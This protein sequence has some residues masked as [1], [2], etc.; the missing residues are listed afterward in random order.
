MNS[1]KKAIYILALFMI[2][3]TVASASI[4][5]ETNVKPTTI[6][7]GDH[8]ELNVDISRDSS[9]NIIEPPLKNKLGPFKV[10]EYIRED[11]INIDDDKIRDRFSYRLSTYETGE[12][13]IS[14][15]RFA[16]SAGAD[17]SGY[18]S[19]GEIRI[20]VQSVLSPE[21]S[22]KIRTL[23]QTQSQ[24]MPGM[25]PGQGIQASPGKAQP[26]Q[27]QSP[28]PPIKDDD[29]PYQIHRGLLFWLGII[30]ATLIIATLIYVYSRWR[31]RKIEPGSIFSLS[32]PQEPPH[33]IALRE[34]AA[35]LASQYISAGQFKK[36][37]TV[38]S[39]IVREYI[40]R[41]IGVPALELSTSETLTILNE[42]SLPFDSDELG[43]LSDTLHRCDLVKFAKLTPP[44]DWHADTVEKAKVFVNTTS[45]SRENATGENKPSHS[46]EVS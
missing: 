33:E 3:S 19:T 17:S 41:R 38:L 9:V 28:Q 26:G 44:D 16:Y 6:T 32:A 30:L 10:L 13:T 34:L 21:D 24:M 18:I 42:L 5:I 7:V 27:Q 29:V 12:Y 35:L 4:E 37:Y 31:K 25:T 8:I 15:I 20:Q 1:I 46:E 43:I 39:E 11:P 22:A 23:A 36:F 40:E 2:I 45:P 14:P